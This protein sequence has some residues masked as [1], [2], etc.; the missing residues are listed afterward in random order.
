MVGRFFRARRVLGRHSKRADGPGRAVERLVRIYVIID[1]AI[2]KLFASSAYVL[3]I[4]VTIRADQTFPTTRGQQP[5]MVDTD[6]VLNTVKHGQLR[7]RP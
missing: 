6:A 7:L 3:E 2:N 4:N 5:R 1:V